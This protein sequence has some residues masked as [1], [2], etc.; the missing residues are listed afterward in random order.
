MVKILIQVK[1]K[2]FV[3]W[4]KVFDLLRVCAPPAA[5]AHIRFSATQVT[6]HDNDH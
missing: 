3:E 4:K 6:Q 1:V 2:D 5:E